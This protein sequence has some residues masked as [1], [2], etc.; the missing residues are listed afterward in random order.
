MWQGFGARLAFL[1][2]SDAPDWNRGFSRSGLPAYFSA[3]RI[4]AVID[5]V[6]TPLVLLSAQDD[7]AV[8]SA[9]F[10][11]VVAAAAHNPWVLAYETPRGGHFGFDVAYGA[12]YLGDVIELMID[13]GVLARW[14]AGS[15]KR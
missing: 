7:P 2:R 9:E 13:P 15:N 1:R 10:H 3:T 8:L 5:R 12:A 14:R 6:R 4:A 11:E